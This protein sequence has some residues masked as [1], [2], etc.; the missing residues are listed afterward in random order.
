MSR[1]VDIQDRWL[2]VRDEVTA[3][4]DRVPFDTFAAWLCHEKRYGCQAVSTTK[5]KLS[6]GSGPW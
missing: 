2:L 1:A 4:R 6:S 3:L 5:R